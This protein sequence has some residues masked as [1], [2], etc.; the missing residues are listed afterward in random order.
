MT[1]TDQVRAFAAMALKKLHDPRALPG[2]VAA[3]GRKRVYRDYRSPVSDVLSDFG[4]MA[5][6]ALRAAVNDPNQ[7]VRLAAIEFVLK[8]GDETD[9][10]CAVQILAD[11]DP[12]IRLRVI[13]AIGYKLRE[14]PVVL[15]ALVERLH[16]PEED[17]CIAAIEALGQIRDSSSV[18][19]LI[20]CL[21]VEG[22][23]AAAADALQEFDS[24]AARNALKAW[25]QRLPKDR[26]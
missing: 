15:Q 9:A 3:L 18:P 20:E 16:D 1:R 10:P 19:P 25:N 4:E 23:G 11:P 12:D 8:F 6:P 14:S 13:P 21:K 17:V 7:R 5:L 2:L 22:L 24:R 26:P